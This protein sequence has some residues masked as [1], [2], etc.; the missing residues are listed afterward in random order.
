MIT[1]FEAYTKKI[2]QSPTEELLHLIYDQLVTAW[3]KMIDHNEDLTFDVKNFKKISTRKVQNLIDKGANVNEHDPGN[4]WGSLLML[5]VNL[6]DFNLVKCLVKNGADLDGL[7]SCHSNV[8]YTAAGI[9]SP[10]SGKIL[11]YLIEQGANI[12]IPNNSIVLPIYS[13]VFGNNYENAIILLKAGCLI[14]QL[15]NRYIIEND[16]NYWLRANVPVA[17]KWAN[18]QFQKLLCEM[19]PDEISKI[20]YDKIHEKI[21]KEYNY[22]F[23]I[24]KYNL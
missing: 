22:L 8:I 11:K 2:K 1:L 6:Q 16:L 4:N 15:L 21:K 10:I 5:A 9:K 24:N 19:H 14:K 17:K 7:N 3:K 12:N 23:S 13:A 20:D 18:Y